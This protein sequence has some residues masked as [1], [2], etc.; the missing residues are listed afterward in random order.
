MPFVLRRS[1]AFVAAL[2][3]VM[4]SVLVAIYYVKALLR[5]DDVAD[6]NSALSYVDRRLAGGNSIVIDQE[7][8]LEAEALIP[9][10]A[11]FR[12]R[13]DV[14]VGD[15]NPLTPTFAESWFRY[16]L[17]PRRP[18]DDARWVVCYRCDPSDLGSY[19]VRWHDDI[20]ISIVER[21]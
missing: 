21:R 13:V 2:F 16:F 3:A 15:S 10:H 5:L 8:A 1:A 7:A 20:G 18:A 9:R 6:T 12:V 17:M 4:G 11:T 14:A 19:A